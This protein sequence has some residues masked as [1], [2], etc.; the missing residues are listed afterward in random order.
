MSSNLAR[1]SKSELRV[2]EEVQSCVNI[3]VDDDVEAIVL[4]ANFCM[5]V[6]TGGK[7][8][9]RSARVTIIFKLCRWR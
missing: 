4:A 8:A 5:T 3:L 1:E 9:G 7:H 6:V 2:R